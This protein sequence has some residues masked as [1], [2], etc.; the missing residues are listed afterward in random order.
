MRSDTP[1]YHGYRFPPEIIS[2]AV[3]LYHRFCVSFRDVDER[4][5]SELS[6]RRSQALAIFQSRRTVSADTSRANPSLVL[7]PTP[8][9]GLGVALE[10]LGSQFCERARLALFDLVGRRIP[11]HGGSG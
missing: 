9:V 2:H 5:A 7:F 3:G 8:L 6:S 4:E 11:A 1:S 10:V